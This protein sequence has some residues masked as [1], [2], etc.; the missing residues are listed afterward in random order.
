M[1]TINTREQ[2]QDFSLF[3]DADADTLDL[4]LREMKPET[5]PADAVLFKKGDPGGAM[6]LITAGKVR[7]FLSDAK[8]EEFTLT[9][10]GPGQIFGEFALLDGSPR[11]TSASTLEPTEL[12]AL[13][14][15]DF[16]DFIETHPKIGIAMIRSLTERLRYITNYLNRV[17]SLGQQLAKGDYDTVIKQLAEASR[18][19]SEADIARL[20]SAFLQMVHQ[21]KKRQ[22]GG[23]H[24]SIS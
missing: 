14:R 17:T 23:S 20:L 10:N 13:D 22:T 4:L 16:L 8:G 18:S 24:Q 12:L 7:I 2:L 15:D 1:S 6:Y 21:V 11:S 5:Y 19:E 3:K 9:A